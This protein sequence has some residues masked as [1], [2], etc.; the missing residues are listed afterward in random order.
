MPRVPAPE[1]SLPDIESL[2]LAVQSSPDSESV[3]S[4]DKHQIQ[5]KGTI[6]ISSVGKDEPIVTRKELWSY[7]REM[8][9]M[10]GLDAVA[11]CTSKRKSL[12]QW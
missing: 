2:P 3:A 4:K 10:M 9:S 7:Y 12:L 11:N 1:N 6:L 5:P 8:W